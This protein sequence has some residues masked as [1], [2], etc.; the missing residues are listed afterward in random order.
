MLWNWGDG[1]QSDMLGPVASGTAV[2]DSHTWESKGT[3]SVTVIVEDEYGA[4]VTASLEV[5]MP[6]SQTHFLF[7]DWFFE[8]FPRLAN[9][10]DLFF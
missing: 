1:S 9:L 8:R 4:S 7:L 5:A 6:K 2:S 3:Y 10:I